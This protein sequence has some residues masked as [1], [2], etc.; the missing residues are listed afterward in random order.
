MP[1]IPPVKQFVADNG[2]RIYRI[3][4][5][6]LPYLTARVYLLLGAGP[7]TLVDTGSGQDESTP[8]ILSGL[9]A[10][11]RDFGEPIRPGDIRRILITHSHRDHAGGLPDL[12]EQTGAEVAVHPLESR[13]ITACRESMVLG[14]RRLQ[15]F[16]QQAGVE[17][18]ERERLLAADRKVAER[19]RNV[20]VGR[21]IADG[22]QLDGLRFIHTPGHSP[23]LLCIVVGNILLSSDHILARTIPQQWPESLAAYTGLGHYFD[24]LDKI[25]RLGGFDLALAGH[26]PVIHNVYKRIDAIR[27]SHLRRLDRLVDILCKAGR[28]MT[29]RETAAKMYLQPQG[30]RL[31]LAL[32]DVAARAEHLYQRGQ[33]AV[34]NLEEIDSQENTAYRYCPA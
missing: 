2:V 14:N 11:Q 15:H 31:V 1:E 7:P 33:L 3:A 12:V 29:I 9:E 18:Q 13:K 30:A 21:M 32:C 27:Q 34:A 28:P 17:P 4:C 23:G 20:A 26:E 24:S 25:S 22:Q 8:Q 10:V 16:L 6:V 5:R 19:L